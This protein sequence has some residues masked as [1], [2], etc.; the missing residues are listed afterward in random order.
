MKVSM[1]NS[2]KKLYGYIRL[3]SAMILAISVGGVV[4][5]IAGFN[6]FQAYKLIFL[7]AFGSTNSIIAT[8]IHATP[9]L[10][11][12]LAFIVAREANILN[13]GVEGQIYIGGL[14]AGLVGAYVEGLPWI[15][16]FPLVLISSCLAAGLYSALA[17]YLKVKYGANE[18]IVTIMLNYIANLT[19]SY[20]VSYPLRDEFGVTQTKRIL[21]SA[22]LG[23]LF[24]DYSLSYAIVFAVVVILLVS[25]ILKNTIFGFRLRAVGNNLLTAETSGI[26]SSKI[27]ISVMFLSGIISGLAGAVLVSGT[28]FR[29]IVNFSA[30]YGF[31]G[32]AVATLA[33]FDPLLLLISGILWG[34][35][36]AGA[37][38]LNRLARIPLDIII[39]IQAFVVIFVAAPN[40]LDQ[41]LKPFR[42]LFKDG[43]EDNA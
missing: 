12:G 16:H 40:L 27:L 28:Y 5:N 9:L 38:T 34:G 25:Y 33:S 41:I 4:F 24:S 7:G 22:E 18:V 3:L 21:E 15:I 37:A 19:C 30:G 10:F 2:G 29:F 14:V 26:K 13:L 39:I 35:L 8:L 42:K 31:T 1:R 20:L 17:G 43:D 36:K 11:S 6:P 32:I 23:H